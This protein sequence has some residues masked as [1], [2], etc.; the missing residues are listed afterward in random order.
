MSED[1][2]SFHEEIKARIG[3]ATS[4]MRGLAKKKKKFSGSCLGCPLPEHKCLII[5]RI[6]LFKIKNLNKSCIKKHKSLH[7]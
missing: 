3:M 2:S 5:I 4:A 1:G 6:I 7:T